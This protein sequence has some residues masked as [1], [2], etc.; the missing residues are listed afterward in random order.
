[1]EEENE[2]L[3]RIWVAEEFTI[4]VIKKRKR[5]NWNIYFAKEKKKKTSKV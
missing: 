1:M 3:G 2:Q 4:N 5:D